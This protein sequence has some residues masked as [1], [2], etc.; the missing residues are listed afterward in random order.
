MENVICKNISFAY[1]ANEYPTLKNADFSVGKGELCLVIGESGAGKSTLLKLLKRE[2]APAGRLSGEIIINGTVGYVAQNID[3]SIVC[4]R[5]RSEISFGLTNMG[6]SGDAIELLVAETASYFNLEDKLDRD[7]LSLS[8]GEKQMVN[9]A[10]VMVMK[11]DVLVLDEPCSQLDPI[12]SSRFAEMVK[13]L[14]R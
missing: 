1:P 2:I 3:E 8:G 13:K 7:I 14:H 11:P 9:L 5:V 12:S 10:S 4:D 6:M